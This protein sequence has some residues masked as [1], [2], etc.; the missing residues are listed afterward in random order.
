MLFQPPGHAH[1]FKIADAP[2]ALEPLA[3]YSGSD[4]QIDTYLFIPITPP[5]DPDVPIP[6]EPEPGTRENPYV[7]VLGQVVEHIGDT[8]VGNKH[9]LISVLSFKETFEYYLTRVRP[10]A[11]L[12]QFLN[13]TQN[14]DYELIKNP[15]L[16]KITDSIAVADSITESTIRPAHD[17]LGVS[18]LISFKKESTR[19]LIDNLLM[20]EFFTAYKVS[21]TWINPGIGYPATANTITLEWDGSGITLRN[22]KL[23][24]TSAYEAVRVNKNTRGND[25]IVFRDPMWPDKEVLHFEFEYLSSTQAMDLLEFMRTTVGHEITLTDQYA[26]EWLGYILTPEAEI[27]QD[28]R[29][30]FGAKFDFQGVL[31]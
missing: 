22:P 15:N 20:A 12:Q 14:F 3:F 7:V 2:T 6:P 24:D 21:N 13:I 28:K 4:E 18:Q 8:V 11:D 1:Y 19:H 23:G 5:P 31:T 27:V 30:G 10:M 9:Q 25:L 29:V 16:F 17:E 26:R